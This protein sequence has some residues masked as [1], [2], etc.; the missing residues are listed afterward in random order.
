MLAR[1]ASSLFWLARYM[2]RADYLARL[3]QVAGHMSAVRVDAEGSSEWDS[4]IVAA[5]CHEE[6]YKKYEVANAENVFSYLA[7]DRGNPSSIVN[8]I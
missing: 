2:E 5:G 7:F 1:T 3:L 6:F 4:A 8:C